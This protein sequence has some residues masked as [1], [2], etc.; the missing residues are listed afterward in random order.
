MFVKRGNTYFKASVR[1][2]SFKECEKVELLKVYSL[3]SA[4]KSLDQGEPGFT[5]EADNLVR[6]FQKTLCVL[7]TKSKVEPKV[8]LRRS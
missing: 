1:W 4:T 5:L 2:V 6:V 8:Y 7:Y 3:A